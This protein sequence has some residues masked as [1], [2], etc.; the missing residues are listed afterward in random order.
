MA[1]EDGFKSL[2]GT[3]GFHLGVDFTPAE[4]RG[5]VIQRHFFE[6]QQREQSAIIW[7]EVGENELRAGESVTSSWHVF[8]AGDLIKR[9]RFI[10][11]LNEAGKG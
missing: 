5:D 6:M 10:G 11:R 9:M 1:C 8:S 2:P 7:R 3:E 4:M